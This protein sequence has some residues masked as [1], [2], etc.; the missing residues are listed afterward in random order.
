MSQ[1]REALSGIDGNAQIF[2]R[3][4]GFMES[5]QRFDGQN[6]RLSNSLIWFSAV[7]FSAEVDGS[8]VA[9][10]MIA[11][12]QWQDAIEALSDAQRD[13]AETLY[14]NLQKAHAPLQLGS[15]ILRFDQPHV[16]GILNMTPDSFSDGGKY[17]DDP[18]AA[19]DSGFAMLSAGATLIDIGGESTRPNA[20]V[21]WEGDEINRVVPIVERLANGGTPISIDTR[22]AAVMEAALAA[23]AHVVNDVSA[24]QY[25]KR[26]LEVVC[27]AECPVVLMHSPSSG[28]NPHEG[29]QYSNVVTD[30]FSALEKRISEISA[31]G[32]KHENILVDVG[33]GFGKNLSDNLALIN[34]IGMFH[35]LGQP[36]LFG[37][38][39]KRMI[40]ALSNEVS[41]DQRLGGSIGLAA[42]AFDSG[43]QIVRVHDVAET[44][45]LAQV[46][47]GLRDAALTAKVP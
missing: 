5:P 36:I 13:R 26:S 1:I 19:A 17:L 45:Q 8:C 2:L 27:A 33:L 9:R 4:M 16:M 7:E 30:V 6:A 32:V 35:A 21:I 29:G 41:V 20:D 38:S 47:R 23:G 37:A 15:R 44:V 40:G 39:R 42:R 22:K 46:W 28:E 12:E 34:N 24:L 3:P 10:L 31:A 14:A 11:V 25:D 43:A 18:Q